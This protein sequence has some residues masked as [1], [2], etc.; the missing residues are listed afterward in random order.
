MILRSAPASPFG[1]KCKLAAYIL[2]LM[3]DIEVTRANPMDP[4]DSIREE[5]PLGKIPAL[6]LDDG[7]TIYDSR[8]ICEYFDSLTKGRKLFPRGE[9]RWAAI[10]LQALG[11]G[12]LEAAILQVYEKRL[13]PEEKRHPDWVEHQ[14]GKVQRGLTWLEANT[15]PINSKPHI[16]DITLACVLGYLDFRFDGSWRNGHPNL[17]AWLEGFDKAVPAFA[18]T[19]PHA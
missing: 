7:S 12:M 11:D 2:G 6:I 1:R 8:V 9:T 4:I 16:G 10:T 14:Q 5:N 3:D 15:P 13:R 18:K 19:A 17:I